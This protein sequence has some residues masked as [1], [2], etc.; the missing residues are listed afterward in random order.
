MP[1]TENLL[2]P[3][4]WAEPFRPWYRHWAVAVLLGVLTMGVFGYVFLSLPFLVVLVAIVMVPAT[5]LNAWLGYQGRSIATAETSVL[6]ARVVDDQLELGG[7]TSPLARRRWASFAPGVLSLAEVGATKQ[8]AVLYAIS[9]GQ[10]EVRFLHDS[11]VTPERLNTAMEPVRSHG[12]RVVV[13][14]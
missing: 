11:D 5:A 8:G 9:D 6:Q 10:S 12:V 7:M 3:P 2:S 14:D 13:R 1:H 4:A